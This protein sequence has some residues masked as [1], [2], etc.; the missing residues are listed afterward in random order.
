M[1]NNRTFKKHKT[2]YFPELFIDST[3]EKYLRQYQI[4]LNATQWLLIDEMYGFWGRLFF[5]TFYITATIRNQ[6]IFGTI[7]IKDLIKINF[8]K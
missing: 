1:V 5:K 7:Y 2:G 4:E 6:D 3:A 8:F